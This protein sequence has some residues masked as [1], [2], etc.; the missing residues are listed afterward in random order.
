[1]DLGELKRSGLDIIVFKRKKG[2]W[3]WFLKVNGNK[4]INRFCIYVFFL[5][6]FYCSFLIRWVYTVWF[7]FRGEEI[8]IWR[9]Y[10]L[11]KFLELRLGEVSFVLL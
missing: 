6:V 2:L 8:V 4:M 9:G 1:M 11:C 5:F 3:I 10:D 7:C